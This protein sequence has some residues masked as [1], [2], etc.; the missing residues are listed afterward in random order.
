M[1][2]VPPPSEQTI[3]LTGGTGFIGAH[4]IREF[5]A[6]G[7]RLRCAVRSE[8]SIDAIK[9]AHPPE[10]WEKLSFVVVPDMQAPHAFDE[11][12]R[13]VNGIIHGASPFTFRAQDNVRDIL[14][15]AI[16]GTL[17]ILRAAAASNNPALT[18]VVVTSSFAAIKDLDRGLRPGYVYSERD[19]NPATYEAAAKT[20]SGAWAYCAS[21]GLAER[22]A[23]Q[24]MEETKPSF[25]LTTINPPWVIGPNIN[26]VT[27]LSSLNESTEIIYRLINGSQSSAVPATDFAG[28]ADVRDVAAAHLLAYE[29][30]AAAG[31]RFLIAS[32]GNFSYQT[33]CDIIR[34]EFPE[35]AASGKVPVGTPG[36]GLKEEVYRLDTTKAQ[37]VLG[38][39]FREL[40]ESVRDCVKVLLR[41]EKELGSS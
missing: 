10:H 15:P 21:K 31:Q 35:L 33:A 25:T 5:L 28:S 38:M 29:T 40:R 34:E 1:A 22:A 18:R 19:W 39:Q 9:Q 2:A 14:E 37:T 36:A 6:K 3:L 12:V 24:F 41:L 11:A 13:G 7:Y 30:P 26:R 17:N 8:Q 32:P 23:W 16:Q 4:I 27:S 20:D